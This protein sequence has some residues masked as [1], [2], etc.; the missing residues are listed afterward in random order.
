MEY[1][2]CFVRHACNARLWTTRRHSSHHSSFACMCVCLSERASVSRKFLFSI[3]FV[4]YADSGGFVHTVQTFQV[5]STSSPRFNMF[6]HA[7]S[8]KLQLKLCVDMRLKHHAINLMFNNTNAHIVDRTLDAVCTHRTPHITHN[9]THN[10]FTILDDDYSSVSSENCHVCL[11]SFSPEIIFGNA[12]CACF[13]LFKLKLLRRNTMC[14]SKPS[15]TT[16]NSAFALQRQP[17]SSECR[18]WIGAIVISVVN[19]D[20]PSTALCVAVFC[21]VAKTVNDR[22]ECSATFFF[23]FCCCLLWV[24][25]R[26]FK[27]PERSLDVT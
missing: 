10:V 3:F 25:S 1:D 23:C 12:A 9:T 22:F 14:A 16:Q 19:Y 27:L 4:A 18:S 21:V 15:A 20:Q 26:K 24:P 7:V 5:D 6:R 17:Y 13:V 11:H 2:A 8:A